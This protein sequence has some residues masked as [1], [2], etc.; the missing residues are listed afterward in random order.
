MQ[1]QPAS[2][3]NQEPSENP[4]KTWQ[5]PELK[6]LTV[7]NGNITSYSEGTFGSNGHS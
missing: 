5:E 6:T 3:A 2:P 1:N 7:K 4:K